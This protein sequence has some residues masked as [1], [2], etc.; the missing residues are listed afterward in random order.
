M[1]NSMRASSYIHQAVRK[2]KNEA[3]A[4]SNLP[5]VLPLMESCM[6][7]QHAVPKSKNEFRGKSGLSIAYK[8]FTDSVK[9]SFNEQVQADREARNHQNQI[10]INAHETKMN[11]KLQMRK[12]L[13]KVSFEGEEELYQPLDNLQQDLKRFNQNSSSFFHNKRYIFI[14]L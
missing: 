12:H 13:S 2:V 7:P 4:K 8:I 11:R 3:N 10:I 9:R 1:D 14:G 5:K 6:V